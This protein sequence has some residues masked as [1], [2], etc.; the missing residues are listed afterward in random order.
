MV[1]GH[2]H[3]E[4]VPG[5]VID[6]LGI[7]EPGHADVQARWLCIVYPKQVPRRIG[8]G[9]VAPHDVPPVGRKLN[10]LSGEATHGAYGTVRDHVHADDLPTP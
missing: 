3:T 2:T 6:A 8:L 1:A 4:F 5:D 9:G 7:G 10:Q